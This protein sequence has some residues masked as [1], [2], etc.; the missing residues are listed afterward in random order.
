MATYSGPEC[1]KCG[2]TERY[3]PRESKREKTGACVRCKSRT[4]E[5]WREEN[6]EKYKSA[7]LKWR[8]E[9]P[10]RVKELERE[11]QKRRRNNA[12]DIKK[13][14]ARQVIANKVNR[15]LLDR[16]ETLVCRRCDS[17]AVDYHH[18]DYD[19]AWLVIPLCKECHIKEHSAE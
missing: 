8:A 3:L 14:R 18:P 12:E 10:E 7:T 11:R 6:P 17:Q 4:T 1:K 19:T 15:G 16:I 5:S 2:T 9:H 13:I